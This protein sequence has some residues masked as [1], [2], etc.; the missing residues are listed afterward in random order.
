MVSVAEVEYR[1]I[2]GFP[3]YRASSGGWIESI[4][5]AGRWKVM[6][7]C[8]Q[9]TGYIIITTKVNGEKRNSS[10]HRMVCLGFHGPCPDGMLCCHNDGDATN[11]HP[12]NLRWDTDKGNHRDRAIHGRT[13]RGSRQGC[14]RLTEELIPVIRSLYEA[15]ESARRIAKEMGVGKSTI[16]RVVTR[17]LWKHVA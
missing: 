16:E 12:S 11:N 9:K 8:R 15:G 10:V 17:K 3:G 7:G 4:H 5:I 6:K 2:P 14:A 1:D 13:A